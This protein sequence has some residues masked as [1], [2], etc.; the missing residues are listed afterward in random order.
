[1]QG[2]SK[3]KVVQQP[4]NSKD[5]NSYVKDGTISNYLDEEGGLVIQP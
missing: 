2:Q 1:M 3:N 4:M 5:Y